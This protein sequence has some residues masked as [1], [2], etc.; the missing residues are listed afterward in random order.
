MTS[1]KRL[2]RVRLRALRQERG[3]SL[4]DAAVKSGLTKPHLWELE[5]GHS[6]NPTLDTMAALCKIYQ[7]TIAYLIG[8]TDKR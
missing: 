7:T 8:E 1:R 6:S 3:W 5:V 2:M 4:M